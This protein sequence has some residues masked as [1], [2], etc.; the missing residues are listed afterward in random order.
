MTEKEWL[1]GKYADELIDWLRESGRAD[2]RKSRLFTCA[3]ARLMWDGFGHKT[4][5][6]VVELAED[7]AD[8]LIA[9]EELTAAVAVAAEYREQHQ[10]EYDG[11]EICPGRVVFETANEDA[12]D[13]AWWAWGHAAQVEEYLTQVPFAEPLDNVGLLREIFGNPFRTPSLGPAGIARAGSTVAA[14]ARAAYQERV[15]PHGALDN[16]RLGVLAD[17]LE[18]EGCEDTEILKHLRGRGRHVRGCWVIDLILKEASGFAIPP[19]RKKRAPKPVEGPLHT[20][21]DIL[22]AAARLAATEVARIQ[23]GLQRLEQERN[24]PRP[25]K[26]RTRK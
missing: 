14:L 24:A 4:H 23:E 16:I 13:G 25:A 12:A 3:L 2:A 15:L 5:K 18:E 11:A 17:A 6:R 22:A 1:S 21:E 19:K 20:V 7:F 8:G 26:K 9:F 10:T